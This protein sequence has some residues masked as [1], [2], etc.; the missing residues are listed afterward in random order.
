MT[1]VDVVPRARKDRRVRAALLD[2]RVTRVFLDLRASRAK[3]V[4]WA[5]RVPSVRPVNP[6]SKVL[7]VPK[8]FRVF[9]EPPVLKDRRVSKAI[10]ATR[11]LPDRLDR[12]ERT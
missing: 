11:D 6:A 3:K 9:L 4:T 5:R 8:V 10:P 2:L 7:R 1:S 12:T